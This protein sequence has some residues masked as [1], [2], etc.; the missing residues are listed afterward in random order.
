MKPHLFV[1]VVSFTTEYYFLT[2]PSIRE[3]GFLLISKKSIHIIRLTGFY[4]DGMGI[5]ILILIKL[6]RLV[7]MIKK[8]DFSRL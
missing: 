7:G 4:V 8:E 3:R 2:P 1:D 5:C 6:N